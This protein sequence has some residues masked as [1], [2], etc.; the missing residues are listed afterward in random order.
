MNESHESVRLDSLD[1]D[2]RLGATAYV[3][4]R[5]LANW[6][7]QQN[8]R[9]IYEQ[10]R[11]M[12]SPITGRNYDSVSGDRALHLARELEH[13]HNRVLT[14]VYKNLN[15]LRLLPVDSSVP[16]GAKTHTIERERHSG[17]MVWF[18]GNATQR[19]QVNLE[20]EEKE[21]KIHAAITSIKLNFWDLMAANFSGY[22]LESKLRQ[23][24]E[25]VADEFVNEKA[26][27]GDVARGVPGM[28]NA[29]FAPKTTAAV[30]FGPG[31]G[32]PTAQLAELHRLANLIGEQSD[33]KFF[34]TAFAC[35][36]PYVNYWKNTIL[37]TANASNRSIYDAFL[38][39]NDYIDSIEVARECA[40][41][42]PGNT[43][44]FQFLRPGDMDSAHIVIPQGLTYMP[45]RSVTGFEMDMDAYLLFGGV[46]QYNPLN[47]L[48]V[49][50]TYA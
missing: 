30:V 12:P 38:Q 39:D 47:N 49:Y 11:N 13:S 7:I 20:R 22:A 23:A 46:N 15:A 3:D 45:M 16:A 27:T 17:E 1:S 2:Q 25:R 35:P 41:A 6:R 10:S 32:T 29:P 44:I 5:Q 48:I 33:D 34:S 9:F 50:A 21:Y 43:D 24:A 40:G 31:G 8:A 4:A 42:G 14:D 18:R 37:D 26:M 28:F 19:G 36:R